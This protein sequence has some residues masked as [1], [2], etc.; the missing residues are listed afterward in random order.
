MD[1]S[2]IQSYKGEI[3]LKEGEP[4]WENMQRIFFMFGY[5]RFSYS[6]V[7]ITIVFFLVT[8]ESHLWEHIKFSDMIESL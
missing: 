6:F 3:L 7:K 5:F 2:I 4:L 8:G 1:S